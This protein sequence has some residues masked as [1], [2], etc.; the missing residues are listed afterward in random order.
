MLL[1]FMPNKRTVNKYEIYKEM[2]FTLLLFNTH[3]LTNGVRK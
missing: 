3:M 2:N 1:Q